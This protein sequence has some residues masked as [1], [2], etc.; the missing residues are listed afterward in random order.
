MPRDMAALLAD[1]G[2]A[3]LLAI[4]VRS[5]TEPYGIVTRRGSVLSPAARLM[6]D[7]LT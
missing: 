3:R 1:H 5:R 4:E 7:E 2:L 6:I